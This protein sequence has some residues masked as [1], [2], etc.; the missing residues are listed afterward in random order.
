MLMRK[1]MQWAWIG[2]FLLGPTAAWGVDPAVKC[3]ADKLKI[4]GKYAFCRLLEEAKAT[5]AF[6]QPDFTKCDAAFD[7]KWQQ[8]EQKTA[9]KG[10]SCWTTGDVDSVRSMI[11][12]TSSDVARS[13]DP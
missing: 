8:S 10:T 6:R 2:A 4:A 3:E 12:G 7:A 13:L 9:L 1:W 5:R 11:A